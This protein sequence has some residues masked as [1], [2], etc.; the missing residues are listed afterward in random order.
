M[1][2]GSA[3]PFAPATTTMQFSPVAVTK[4]VATGRR[5]DAGDAPQ[6][7]H[8]QAEAHRG[9]GESVATDGAVKVNFRAGTCRR[10]RLVRT[11]AA[12]YVANELP[13]AFPGPGKRRRG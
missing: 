12:G 3:W 4:I 9:V 7:G 8:R 6:I 5:I 2:A 11:L 13:A 10:E 1:D